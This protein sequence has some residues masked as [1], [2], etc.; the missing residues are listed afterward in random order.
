RYIAFESYAT[1]LVPGSGP[2]IFVR[3]RVAGTTQFVD[4][5]APG[6]GTTQDG[7][8]SDVCGNRPLALS[9]NGRYLAWTSKT[10]NLVP[11]DTTDCADT[12]VR[13]L[14]TG[15]TERVSVASDGSQQLTDSYHKCSW[16][17]PK[18]SN[19]GRFVAFSS[20]AWN[21]SPGGAPRDIINGS[22]DNHP[23]LHD[24]V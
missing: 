11:N 16:Y 7:Q 19:D 18:I 17:T 22:P 2:G 24:R 5:W 9:G 21:L 14:A 13:D 12:F 23:Y 8:A 10:A 4:G 20:A 6:C 3:D 15:A 1:N